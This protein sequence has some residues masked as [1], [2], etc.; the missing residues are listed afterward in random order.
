MAGTTFAFTATVGATAGNKMIL[1]A[2]AL[3]LQN[4]T[5]GDQLGLLTEPMEC[6]ACGSS[7]DDEFKVTFDT[8]VAE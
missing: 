6:L 1:T 2:P 8:D 3:Q 4:V 7:G 5:T